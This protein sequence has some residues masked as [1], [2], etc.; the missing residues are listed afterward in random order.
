[1]MRK[2]KVIALLIAIVLLSQVAFGSL[3]AFAEEPPPYTP[4]EDARVVF[5]GLRFQSLPNGSIQAFLDVSVQHIKTVA[6]GFGLQFDNRYLQLSEFQTNRALT[7][8][9]VQGNDELPFWSYNEDLG[10]S[11]Q[12]FVKEGSGRNYLETV[13]EHFSVFGMVIATPAVLDPGEELL[14]GYIDEYGRIDAESDAHPMLKLGTISFLVKDPKGLHALSQDSMNELI[15]LYGTKRV[16]GSEDLDFS[17]KYLKYVDDPFD[18]GECP[19]DYVI[20]DIAVNNVLLQVQL[21]T[22]YAETSSDRLYKTGMKQDLLDYMN[23]KMNYVTTYNAAGSYRTDV[24][25]WNDTAVIKDD[26]GADITNNWQANTSGTLTVTQDY[27][28]GDGS[29]F[30]VVA[31]VHVYPVDIIGYDA[32][33]L[34]N[35][36]FDETVAVGEIQPALPTTGL[37][38][39]SR[40]VIGKTVPNA[41]FSWSADGNVL[42]AA[43]PYIYTF[44]GTVSNMPALSDAMP[45]VRS[46]KSTI[47][48]ELYRAD[49]EH[50]ME[51]SPLPN[52]E[53]VISGGTLS[54][55]VSPGE[56]WIDWASGIPDGSTFELR[57][58]NGEICAPNAVTFEPDGTAKFEITAGTLGDNLALLLANQG[59]EL[60]LSITLPEHEGTIY[61]PSD[62]VLVEVSS[63]NKYISGN[64]DTGNYTF[65][66]TGSRSE[67]MP[68]SRTGNLSTSVTLPGGDGIGTTYNGVTGQIPGELTS[69]QVESWTISGDPTVSDSIVTY[70]GTLKECYYG[71]YGKVT[72]PDGVT[73]TLVLQTAPANPAPAVEPIDDIVFN[74]LKEGYRVHNMQI[75]QIP[76]ANAGNATINGLSVEITGDSPEAFVLLTRPVDI[77]QRGGSTV[78]ELTTRHGLPTGEYSA[79]VTISCNEAQSIETFHVHFTVTDQD[80][81]SVKAT[82]VDETGAEVDYGKVILS[83]GESYIAGKPVTIEA[84]PV[85]DAT[86]KSIYGTFL[87]WEIISAPEGFA[88]SLTEGALENAVLVFDM[89]LGDVKLQAVFEETLISKMR[90]EK[91]TAF[92]GPESNRAYEEFPLYINSGTMGYVERPFDST[93][94]DYYVIVPNEY[95]WGKLNFTFRDLS[96]GGMSFNVYSG[97]NAV[98]FN[99]TDGTL[100]ETDAFALPAIMPDSNDVMIEIQVPVAEDETSPPTTDEGST[101]E[102]GSTSPKMEYLTY[103]FHFCRRM[104]SEEFATFG[105]GNTPYGEIMYDQSF[106]PVDGMTEDEAR[107]KRQSEEK[108]AFDDTFMYKDV[109]YTPKAWSEQNADQNEY[110]V[111]LYE[112][113][114]YDDPFIGAVNS[115]GMEIEPTQI[116]RTISLDILPAQ[117][118]G[119]GNALFDE[120]ANVT[121]VTRTIREQ[122][123]YD[124]EIDLFQGQ[125]VRPGIYSMEYSFA[126]YDGTPITV[127][128]I[129]VILANI[130]DVD[131]SGT[132]DGGD[133]QKIEN[134]K[135][136]SMPYNQLTGYGISGILYKYRVCDTNKDEAVNGNDAS[137][138]NGTIASGIP[139]QE[140]Y[141]RL[142]LRVN[143]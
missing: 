14:P 124:C 68:V 120:F 11:S 59:G 64:D 49:A 24:M 93:Q 75:K 105:Y 51:K 109:Y 54:F 33:N 108:A 87:R 102:G 12:I 27:L 98:S 26:S 104:Q 76:V 34:R 127:T 69:V 13:E 126:D 67:L 130:G 15:S 72:N 128:R 136:N 86:G 119:S 36:L 42:N 142:S 6:I 129:V 48:A 10:F 79:V 84:K 55:V 131:V 83:G 58:P 106:T 61:M 25:V 40:P 81:F 113:E 39:F 63:E 22:P 21:D 96:L 5:S 121:T 89:P 95:D 43:T 134:R 30:P 114:K 138:L 91:L 9:E 110:A 88:E 82:A 123:Q 125:R 103:S 133:A 80:V 141:Q 8:E 85:T 117:E 78:M 132:I 62:Y 111:V 71:D 92:A 140:F 74:T 2:K 90:L 116:T 53:A 7:K 122:N 135:V 44:D 66:Y 56:P 4:S 3:L 35:G 70:V 19:D 16:D 37:P 57:L 139:L 73:L 115:L 101:G 137:E 77:L 60:E 45:W 94:T 41:Q 107:D 28:G 100:F 31:T 29:R 17:F 46:I 50:S 65:V 38:L 18:L 118:E 1:M 23:T 143:G 112:G 20:F 97:T 47:Q 52:A 32:P 99:S